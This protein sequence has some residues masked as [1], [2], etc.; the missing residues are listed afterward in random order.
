VREPRVLFVSKPIAPPWNDGSKNLVRDVATHLTRARATVMTTPTAPPLDGR[1]TM[2]PVYRDAG[3]F[4]PTVTS[5]ARIVGRLVSGDAHDA[6]HFVFA[7]D[8]VSSSIAQAARR[9]RRTF[10]WRGAVVQTVASAPRSFDGIGRWLF[11]DV[12]IAHSEHTRGRLLGAGVS[13][14]TLRV[15]PPCVV[16]PRA[17]EPRTVRATFGFD[18]GPIILYPGDYDVSR[19]AETVA[20][21][22]PAI[23]GAFPEA[24]IV[25]AC[26]KKVAAAG[27]AQR[28]IEQEL[29]RVGFAGRTRHL[30]E[31]TDMAELLSVASVVVFP[32]DELH[33]K[34]DIPLVLLEAMA[35]GVPL[36]VARG[37][38][39]EA[40][41]FAPSV[42]AGD[43]NALADEVIGLLLDEASARQVGAEGKRVYNARYCPSVVAKAYDDLYA[44]LV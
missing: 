26:R 18:D 6:W 32:V 7:P 34:L 38:P 33:G 39:L 31:V 20:G 15:I 44:E 21:A 19:G 3:R 8:A 43:P 14:R 28:A 23:V 25:F 24:T 36:V 13:G 37:G 5:S 42:E 27:E 41:D 30:G 11:G 40:L 12:V 4:A 1:V 29:L 10:G 22:V 16:A 35:L 17:H 9:V 2:D